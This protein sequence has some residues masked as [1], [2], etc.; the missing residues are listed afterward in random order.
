M[1]GVEV[2]K[3][4]VLEVA[5]GIAG[6]SSTSLWTLQDPLIIAVATPPIDTLYHRRSDGAL[7]RVARSSRPLNRYV[8]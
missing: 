2:N 1:V 7:R 5:N 8:D 3:V 4:A 6:S